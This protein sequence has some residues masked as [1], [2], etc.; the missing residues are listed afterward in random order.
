MIIEAPF[1]LQ[2]IIRAQS[3]DGGIYCSLPLEGDGVALATILAKSATGKHYA[4][5][6]L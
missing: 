2:D 4:A 6:V 1:S 5:C 3:K